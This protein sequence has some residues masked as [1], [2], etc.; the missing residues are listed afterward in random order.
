MEL[1][2]EGKQAVMKKGSS[3]ELVKE[4]RMF[5]GADSYTLSISLPLK[6]CKENLAIFGNIYRADVQTKQLIYDCELRDKAFSIN[7]VATIV[8]LEGGDVKIQILE[9]RSAQNFNKTFSN[10]YINELSIG[11][12]NITSP[13]AITPLQAWNPKTSQ[14]KYVALPWINNNSDSGLPHNFVAWKQDGTPKWDESVTDVTFQPF[15]LWV[16]KRICQEVGFT[17]DF[18]EWENDKNWKNLL[19]CNVLP[20]AWD[21][22]EFARA[23]PHWT[24]DEFFEKLEQFL[25]G[26]FDID[27]KT[28]TISF[29]FYQNVLKKKQAVLIENVEDELSTEF[30]AE[31]E[32]CDYIERK[33]IVFSDPGGP[34]WKYADCGWVLR[35]LKGLILEYETMDA[36]MDSNKS[37]KNWDGSCGRGDQVGKIL[38]AQDIDCYFIIRSVDRAKVFN[39][40]KLRYEWIYDCILQ[41]INLFGGR[42]TDTR[43][44]ADEI[45]LDI[46]PAQ[47]EYADKTYGRCLFME[48]GSYNEN[49]RQL[50]TEEEEDKN[51]FKTTITQDFIEA[52]EPGEKSEYYSKLYVAFADGDYYFDIMPLPYVE[53]VIVSRFWT[54]YEKSPYS[55]RLNNAQKNKERI[56]Y[57]IDPKKKYNFKF[58]AKSIPDPRAPFIIRG[59]RYICEKLTATITEDGMSEM[60]KGAFYPVQED[61]P[62]P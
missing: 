30:K 28:K 35:D 55:M 50:D 5:T 32:D 33:N 6:G 49:N 57:N 12:P 26:E 39:E 9:G 22:G 52:G 4:N 13:D 21:I 29:S 14:W 46:V 62:M 53:D 11:H 45:E 20:G 41:P 59:K 40:I 1:Y 18:E 25:G 2:L 42:I 19:I 37:L 47:I 10:T 43:D 60:I 58:L 48:P 27:H 38:H 17:A 23:L 3:I 24:V 31:E 56:V 16:A 61:V 8:G 15:L 36:L 7:G 51:S 44:D 34:V 54:G